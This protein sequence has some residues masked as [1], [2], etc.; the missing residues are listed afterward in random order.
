MNELPTYDPRRWRR[1]HCD[2]PGTIYFW[3]GRAG[4]HEA[5]SNFAATPFAMP[6]WLPEIGEIAP[7]ASGEHAFQAAKAQTA[8]AHERIRRAP[9]PL[10]AKRAGRAIPL[11]HGW[12]RRRLDVMLIV[13]RAKFAD[14]D[15]RELLLS[16]G[17]RLLAEDS[18]YDAVWG[19][20]DRGGG[21][22]GA[23]LLGR[24]LLR[25]RDE[26]RADAPS[27]G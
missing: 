25:V 17:D 12:E 3:S 15:L 1:D 21:Y 20:R 16:T 9:T 13:V 18:P 7:W 27:E 22:R 4:E 6:A 2:E 23:N 5:F 24:C 19:C 10:V 11:P 26:L 8:V 14:A